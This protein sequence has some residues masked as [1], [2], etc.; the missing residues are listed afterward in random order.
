MSLID[1]SHLPPIPPSDILYSKAHGVYYT[2]GPRVEREGGVVEAPAEGETAE[3]YGIYK[4]VAESN[5][6]QWV[7][8]VGTVAEV[9]KYFDE[10]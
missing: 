6:W 4:H 2:Y 7:A 1:S 9:T 10:L 3:F 8:D 5:E